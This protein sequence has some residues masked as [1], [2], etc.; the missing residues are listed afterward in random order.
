MNSHDMTMSDMHHQLRLP[1]CKTVDPIFPDGVDDLK[2]GDWI[3]FVHEAQEEDRPG[4]VTFGMGRLALASTS[5][6]M[7]KP[8][9][10]MVVKLRDGELRLRKSR[11]MEHDHLYRAVLEQDGWGESEGLAYVHRIVDAVELDETV[12]A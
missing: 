1:P 8:V 3:A 2:R 6:F 5:H 7:N 4:C 12:A 10:E 9:A 11:M